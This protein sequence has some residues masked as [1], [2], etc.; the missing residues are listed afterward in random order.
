[1]RIARLIW[2][3]EIVLAVIGLLFIAEIIYFQLTYW[4]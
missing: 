2:V 1:M 3:V 4:P